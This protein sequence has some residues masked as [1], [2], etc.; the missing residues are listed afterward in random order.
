MTALRQLATSIGLDPRRLG[1]LRWL[2]KVKVLHQE[3]GSVREHFE[4]LL[5]D[6]E[7]D[8]FT[9]EL[10]NE[11]ELVL[12]IAEQFGVARER[13]AELVIEA[14]S[15]SSM[16]DRLRQATSR[17]LSMKTEPPLGRRLGWYVI[18]RLLQPTRVV[19]TGIHD[20]LGSLVLLSALERNA[21]EGKEG[22]LVS[23]DIDATAGWIVGRHPRW[24]RRIESTRTGLATAL[25]EAPVQMFLHDSLHTYEHERF[26]L[27]CAAGQLPA[28]GLL[29]SDNSHGTSALHD[30]CVAHGF[31]YSYFAERPRAHFYRGAG[32]GLG[33]VVSP[34]APAEG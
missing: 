23:F 32:I 30:V 34:E 22:S 12:W 29:V 2:K 17:R 1:R 26:E 7:I 27:E 6:P 3:G 18:V 9:Y 14:R 16:Y 5:L 10:A 19:E 33:V 25:E 11:D 13:V 20:G 15:N 31:R 4:Y 21:Q 24:S 8:N 28:G